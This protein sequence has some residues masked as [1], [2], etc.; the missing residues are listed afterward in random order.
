MPK[1]CS[2]SIEDYRKRLA[3]VSIGPTTLRNQGASG[4]TEVAR[5]F[6]KKLD[7]TRF[8]H[9]NE[10]AFAQE[11]DHQTELLIKSLPKG[12]QHWGTARKAIN[13][14]LGEVY[15]HRFVCEAYR[16]DKIENF[17]EL[18]LDSQVG[19]FLYR[20]ARKTGKANFPRWLGIKYLT[21]S[22][23]KQYHDFAFELAKSIDCARI[24][25]DLIIWSR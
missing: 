11:L 16:L 4:V 5:E 9:D 18:P 13:L 15:Y 24:H 20:E 14:F 21:A 17:L 1:M 19:N 2:P 7:L 23:S 25:L 3:N 10:L 22:S 6:L 12:A 8:I